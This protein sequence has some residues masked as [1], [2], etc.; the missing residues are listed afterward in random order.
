[1]GQQLSGQM[2]NA[3]P[4]GMMMGSHLNDP[5]EVTKYPY[6]PSGTKSLLSKTLTRDVWEACKDKRDRFGYTF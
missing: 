4:E 3:D 2:V 5:A 1:M 6:F